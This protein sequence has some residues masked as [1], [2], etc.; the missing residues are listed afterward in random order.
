MEFLAVLPLTSRSSAGMTIW[1][2]VTSER[3]GYGFTFCEIV[4]L[5]QP[6]GSW[7]AS[8]VTTSIG[9]CRFCFQPAALHLDGLERPKSP[10]F[11]RCCLKPTVRQLER[12]VR[13]E[14]VIHIV[15]RCCLQPAAPQLELVK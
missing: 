11:S 2:H 13:D 15:R 1:F 3:D 4:A 6:L 14:Y 7:N 5:N 9:L 10:V 8:S 12:L